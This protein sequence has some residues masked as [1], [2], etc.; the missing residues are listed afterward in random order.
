MSAVRICL[1]RWG[2]V[3]L[4]LLS[5]MWFSSFIF[6]LNHGAG[7]QVSASQFALLIGL[8]MSIAAFTLV[9]LFLSHANILNQ[10]IGHVGLLAAGMDDVFFWIVFGGMLV[11]YQN[12]EMIKINESILFAVYLFCL[13]FV[14]PRIVREIVKRIKSAATM[15]GFLVVGCF[16][17]AIIADAVDLHQICGAFAFG[18]M[19]PR[20]NPLI[21]Q[22]RSDLDNFVTIFLLPVFFAKI[23]AMAN[24][25]LFTNSSVIVFGVLATIIAFATKFLGVYTSSR[26][27]GYHKYESAFLASLL[28][29]RGVV[30]VVMMKVAW[31]VGLITIETFT[32]L[33][34]MALATT[35]LATALAL[36]FKEYI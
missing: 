34:I 31:E 36:Y 25:A 16:L 12:N 2:G 22:V 29:M 10:K 19:L 9:S 23:G 35:W 6:P 26:L 27:I 33:I 3:V 1:F 5:G 18:L 28:N 8:S 32:V 4:P 11:F 20:D 15:M 7:A 13:I 21:L 30:E 24:I 14:F 17:S